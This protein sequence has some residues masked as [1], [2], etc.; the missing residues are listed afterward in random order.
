M[1]S[2]YDKIFEAYI[3]EGMFDRAKAKLA[4]VGQT[5]G[6][7][8]KGATGRSQTPGAVKTG[9]D[10]KSDSIS[11]G[12]DTKLTKELTG[13]NNKL[14]K[15]LGVGSVD[16]IPQALS[17]IDPSFQEQYSKITQLTPAAEPSTPVATPQQAPASEE[18]GAAPQQAPASEEPA[19]AAEPS[20]GG[21]T[22]NYTGSNK[23]VSGAIA[24]LNSSG[25]SQQQ[26]LDYI[27]S[28]RK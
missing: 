6:N 16:E 13:F 12:F 21:S 2:D 15:A 27:K 26:I 19:P 28:K 5:V 25:M 10:A 8:V 3:Q 23:N 11:K 17:Q 14:Q 7:V 4:G 24:K 1:R 9:A 18:P 22:F 20:A